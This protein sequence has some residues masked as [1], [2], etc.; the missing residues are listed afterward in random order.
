M[1][2]RNFLKSLLAAPTLTPILLA[3][4]RQHADS[5]LYLIADAPHRHLPSILQELKS[6]LPL[7]K[8]TFTFSHKHPLSDPMKAS[9]MHAGW[10]WVPTSTPAAMTLS[11]RAMRAAAHPSFSLVRN[12]RIWDIRTR[13]LLAMWE[14]MNH[15]PASATV[16]TAATFRRTPRTVSRG[17][18]AFL[19]RD[20][21]LLA[22]LPL[23][24]NI[25]RTFRD[26]RCS[27]TVEVADGRAW[28]AESSCRHQICRYSPPVSLPGERIVCAPNRLILE[29]SGPGGV[30]TVIG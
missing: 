28:I 22:R 11:F 12:G 26:N 1:D 7:D 9:L 30:D 21:G 5:E 29:V 13:R 16:L 24:R 6:A 18:A 8:S 17:E 20:G 14:D 15:L 25:R 3:S 2:R 23:D 4:Q 10:T 19:L 27:L